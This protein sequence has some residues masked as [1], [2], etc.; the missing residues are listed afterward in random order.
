[1]YEAHERLLKRT[2]IQLT[3]HSSEKLPLLE[4]VRI[5]SS[6]NGWDWVKEEVQGRCGWESPGGGFGGYIDCGTLQGKQR[7][8]AAARA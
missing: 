1:M 4:H 2:V 7:A 5:D 6:Y 8:L 3:L